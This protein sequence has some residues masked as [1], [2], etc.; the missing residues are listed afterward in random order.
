MNYSIHNISQ[1]EKEYGHTEL[2]SGVNGEKEV[3]SK[4]EMICKALALISTSDDKSLSDMAAK[5][6][7]EL[8]NAHA[9]S[10]ECAAYVLFQNFPEDTD[11]YICLASL[12]K[13]RSMEDY[14]VFQ[15]IYFTQKYEKANYELHIFDKYKVINSKYINRYGK[16]ETGVFTGKGAV[17]TVITGGYDDLRDPAYVDTQWDYYCFTDDPENYR[18]NV[19]TLRKLDKMIKNDKVRSQRYA[20]THPYELLPEYDYT[21]YVDGKFMITGDLREYISVFSRGSSMLCFPHPDRQKL[22]DEVEAIKIWQNKAP[23]VRNE[24]DEQV[25]FYRQERYK[26][27]VPMVESACLV[28]QNHDDKLNKVMEGWW[29]EIMTRSNRDQLSLGYIC[30]KQG[31][32]FDISALDIYDNRYLKYYVHNK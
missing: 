1:L 5:S 7:A 14:A 12:Y 22:E 11:K 2:Y 16:T 28:R 26:D 6:I 10:P 23:D 13:N 8:I 19:W 32:Q 20:K 21:I 3:Q 24:L 30:W 9:F 4:L 17:Y 31:Y 27:S 15:A 18:S 25:E 29:N